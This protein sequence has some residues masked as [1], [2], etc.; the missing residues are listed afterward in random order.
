[1]N[2]SKEEVAAVVA[3]ERAA[4]DGVVALGMGGMPA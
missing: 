1:M 2:P 3:E 4:L